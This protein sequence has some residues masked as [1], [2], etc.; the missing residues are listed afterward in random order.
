MQLFIYII[1]ITLGLL[2]GSFLNVCTYRIPRDESIAFP[3]SHCF[4]CEKNLKP[5]DLIPVVSY[6]FLR[7]KCRNCKTHISAQY[8]VIE[9]TNSLIYL[10]LF[11]HFGLTLNFGFYAILSSILIVITIIDYYHKIIPNQLNLI[12]LIMGIIFKLITWFVLKEEN[13]LVDNLLG[14]LIGGGIFLLIAVVT[15]GAM[16]GG[17]IKIMGA[18][19]VWFG[20]KGILLI[21]LLSFVI[22]AVVSIILLITKIKSRKDEIAFGPFICIATL[23]A[24]LYTNEIIH[25]YFNLLNH[26]F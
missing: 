8:P 6:I 4:N 20:V 7:G 17:D 10:L 12:I 5:L 26:I 15:D 22:G 23:L 9:L 14:F 3:S 1:V 11:M 19:G 2:I 24:I 16:G 21:T 18:L 13:E 25:I